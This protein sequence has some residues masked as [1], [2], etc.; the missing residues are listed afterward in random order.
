MLRTLLDGTLVA[1]L[2]SLR[3]M[4]ADRNVA[5]AYISSSLRQYDEVR[6]L[7]LPHRDPI[8]AVKEEGLGDPAEVK[9][10]VLPHS[11]F[12]G[13]GT[14]IA[15]LTTLALCAAITSPNKVFEIGTF[16]GRT[17]AT[18]ILNCPPNTR[19]LSL[20]LPPEERDYESE[21]NFISTDRRLIA[22]RQLASYVYDQGLEDRF[23]QLL[24]DSMEFDPSPHANTVDFG[25]IDGAH[26]LD[27]VRND[28]EKMSKM[29]TE[30]SI[31]FWHDYGG[32]GSFR[33]LAEYLEELGEAAPLY[34]VQG[35]SLAWTF[36]Q[37][38]H[39]AVGRN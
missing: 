10:V 22:Q 18:L 27:F 14:A 17:T 26:G 24:G 9:R 11:P 21:A 31:V 12:S 28:T 32:K 1:N 13:G 37:H 33:P 19:V 7:G 3:L 6:G 30:R 39:A 4:L 16:N 15:E 29:L 25:F 8:F 20:D 23:E 2:A 36:G 5:R 38:L 34:R 35:T